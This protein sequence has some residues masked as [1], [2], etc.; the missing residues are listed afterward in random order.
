M[1][2]VKDRSGQEAKE[3]RD[4]WEMSKVGVSG[5]SYRIRMIGIQGYCHN[6]PYSQNLHENL[7][8]NAFLFCWLGEKTNSWVPCLEQRGE[9]ACMRWVTSK[10]NRDQKSNKRKEFE[11]RYDHENMRVWYF[12]EVLG[13]ARHIPQDV[14]K[15]LKPNLFKSQRIGWP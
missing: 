5:Q 15:G 13:E 3:K 10:M 14:D 9:N 2:R 7:H 8:I 12:A 1:K 4:Q 6:L 11:V